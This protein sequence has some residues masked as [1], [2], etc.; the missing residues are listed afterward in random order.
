MTDIWL[1]GSSSY[2]DHLASETDFQCPASEIIR[3]AGSSGYRISL[4]H[5]LLAGR[6]ASGF[7]TVSLILH[8]TITFASRGVPNRITTFYFTFSGRVCVPIDP[9]KVDQFNPMTVP[10]ITQLTDEIDQVHLEV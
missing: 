4:F 8:F 5:D 9:A 3:L 10:T 2:Q 1:A 6:P 7:T